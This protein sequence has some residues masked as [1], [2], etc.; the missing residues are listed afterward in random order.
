MFARRTKKER[1][2]L[3]QAVYAEARWCKVSW[4]FRAAAS[5]SALCGLRL[6]VT[7]EWEEDS[8]KGDEKNEAEEVG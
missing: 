3:A 6:G 5:H 1:A 8:G 7:A 2:F 4:H